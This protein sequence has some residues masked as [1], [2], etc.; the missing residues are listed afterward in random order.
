MI[1]VNRRLYID[2][3]SG[4]KNQDFGQVSAA[5]ARLIFVAEAVAQQSSNQYG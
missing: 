3:H 1:E 5:I 4:I 2:E